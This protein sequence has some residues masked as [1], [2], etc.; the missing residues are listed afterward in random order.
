MWGTWGA[1]RA[2]DSM[3]RAF[4]Y[5]PMQVLVRHLGDGTEL[6]GRIVETEAYLGPEDQAAHSRGGR[7][8]PRNRGMFMRPGTLYVYL[9]YGMYFCMN[10]SSRGERS[11][12]GAGRGTGSTLA[13]PGWGSRGTGVTGGVSTEPEGPTSPPPA[14]CG[15]RGAD[16]G[17]RR[18]EI[19]RG[20]LGWGRSLARGPV[21]GPAPLGNGSPCPQ[22]SLAIPALGTLH[23]GW[24]PERPM[25]RIRGTGCHVSGPGIELP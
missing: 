1:S 3:E 15:L 4:P 7:Q 6:R 12:A 22:P 8:T 9:I 20:E 23:P 11:W 24:R 10:V 5:C 17:G 25:Q 19:T 16:A 21:T 13:G 2:V 14:Q 18:G